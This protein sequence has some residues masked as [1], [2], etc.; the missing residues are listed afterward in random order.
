MLKEDKL[1]LHRPT[2]HPSMPLLALCPATKQARQRAFRRYRETRS[3]LHLLRI[4]ETALCMLFR[5]VTRVVFVLR[6]LESK[7]V[8]VRQVSYGLY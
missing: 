8:A 6:R 5:I 2:V 1:G 3:V 7:E 4:R